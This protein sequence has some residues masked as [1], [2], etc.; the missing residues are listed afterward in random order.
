ML[1]K[2]HDLLTALVEI[3]STLRCFKVLVSLGPPAAL[4]DFEYIVDVLDAFSDLHG[5][6]IPVILV[7][8]LQFIN[9]YVE[10]TECISMCITSVLIQYMFVPVPS[11][12]QAQGW[13]KL[14]HVSSKFPWLSRYLNEFWLPIY[15]KMADTIPR[16][17][18]VLTFLHLVLK[19]VNH[20]VDISKCV[21]LKENR[22]ILIPNHW[23]LFPKA[24]LTITQHLF[25]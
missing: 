4:L 23:N 20:F 11:H 6:V 14:R 24:Q 12:P 15:I 7:F 22:C 17:F 2:P 21:L 1:R 25:M 18:W 13:Q 5:I 16:T 3:N 8:E 10:M 19:N 9:S